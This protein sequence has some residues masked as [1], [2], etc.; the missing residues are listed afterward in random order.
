ME[1]GQID[2]YMEEKMF[3]PYYGK[4]SRMAD[5][6]IKGKINHLEENKGENFN[7]ISFKNV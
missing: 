5:I 6:N 4:S 7:K 3:D 1:P 2:I